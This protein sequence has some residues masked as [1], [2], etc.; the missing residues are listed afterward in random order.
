VVVASSEIARLLFNGDNRAITGT[1]VQLFAHRAEGARWQPIPDAGFL[2]L[3]NEGP[4]QGG[5]ISYTL[6]FPLPSIKEASAQIEANEPMQTGW[7][8]FNEFPGIEKFW[9]VWA[10]HPIGELEIIKTVVLN[11][12]D[13][14]SIGNPQQRDTVRALLARV[15]ETHPVEDRVKKQT[16]VSGRGDI[17]IY[18]AELEHH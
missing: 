13:K 14:G 16:L 4:T 10:A 15:T 12:Q 3:I 6:L 1:L 5:A 7:Y 2:Y 18:L 11:S 8:E 17:L 9:I